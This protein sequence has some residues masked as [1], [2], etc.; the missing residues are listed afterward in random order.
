MNYSG[1]VPDNLL[2]SDF[3]NVFA[4][5]E[6]EYSGR[7]NYSPTYEKIYSI[8]LESSTVQRLLENILECSHRYLNSDV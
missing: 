1:N 2:S 7:Q 4:L 6:N 3:D 8:R 5:F